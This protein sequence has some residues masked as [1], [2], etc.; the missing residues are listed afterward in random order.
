MDA[1][2]MAIELIRRHDRDL[3][4]RSETLQ[5]QLLSNWSVRVEQ[6]TLESLVVGGYESILET[7]DTLIDSDARWIEDLAGEIFNRTDVES[8]YDFLLE[9]EGYVTEAN[10]VTASVSVSPAQDLRDAIDAA[11]TYDGTDVQTDPIGDILAFA[12]SQGTY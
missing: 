10:N 3:L 2:E 5:K 7:L 4:E 6:L 11:G 9:L 8:L 12:A 1:S